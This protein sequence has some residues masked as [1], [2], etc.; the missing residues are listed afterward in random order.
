MGGTKNAQR[1]AKLALAISIAEDDET[2]QQVASTYPGAL[3][4][5]DSSKGRPLAF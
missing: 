2:R 5:A 4:G 3:P 1:A